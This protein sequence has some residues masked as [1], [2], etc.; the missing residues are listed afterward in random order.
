M[1]SGK[2]AHGFNT[3]PEPSAVLMVYFLPFCSVFN[4]FFCFPEHFHAENL[5]I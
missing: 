4:L 2:N 3:T 5:T 1:F